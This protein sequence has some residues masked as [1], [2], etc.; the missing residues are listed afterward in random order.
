MAD[1][2]AAPAG[3]QVG[4]VIHYFDKAM[5]AVIRLSG[6]LK[7]GETVKIARKEG[8]FEMKVE[9]MQVDHQPIAEGKSGDEVAIKVT[10]P[11]KEGAVV[12]KVAE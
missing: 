10:S 7:S 1:Q 3:E 8:D 2:E 4:K 9:S 5:V 6:G 12:Y 11:T